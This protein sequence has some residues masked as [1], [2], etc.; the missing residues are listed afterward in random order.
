MDD[1]GKNGEM[2]SITTGEVELAILS[3]DPSASKEDQALQFEEYLK[4]K[5]LPVK[6]D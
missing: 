2:K 3:I 5:T 4:E 1:M 6:T